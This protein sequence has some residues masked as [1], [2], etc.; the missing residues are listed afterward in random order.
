MLLCI[1]CSAFHLLIW[2]WQRKNDWPVTL[3]PHRFQN[4]FSEE[5]TCC[6]NTHNHCR[7][8]LQQSQDSFCWSLCFG[9]LAVWAWW[10]GPSSLQCQNIISLTESSILY[11][12]F[13]VRKA[14]GQ[15][16]RNS[17]FGRRCELRYVD[18][19]SEMLITHAQHAADEV[20][21]DCGFAVKEQQSMA[22]AGKARRQGCI[23]HTQTLHLS[24]GK[25]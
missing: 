7:L 3:L 22:T 10:R 23:S 25:R 8:D 13:E 14:W 6:C 19:W 24:A 4:F 2:I 12:K 5:R 1:F 21:C 9:S 15:W 20:N 18:I 17:T 16:N 11:K